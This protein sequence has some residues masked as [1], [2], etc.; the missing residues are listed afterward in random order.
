M[1]NFQD[2]YPL[3]L[4]VGLTLGLGWLVWYQVS[5]STQQ[6]QDRGVLSQSERL[7]LGLSA[8]LGGVL[9][10][11][12]G[13]VASMFS[14]YLVPP[15]LI[16]MFWEGGLSWVGAALGALAGLWAYTARNGKPFWRA[17]DALA[18][19][20][21]WVSLAGWIGCQLNRCAYGRVASGSPLALPMPDLMGSIEPRW[22]TQAA[23]GLLSLVGLILLLRL[24]PASLPPGILAATSLS[25]ISLIAFFTGWFRGDPVPV[26][27]DLRLDGLAAGVMLVLSTGILAYRWK[28]T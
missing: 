2:S 25:W 24:L 4:V 13:H 27:G 5:T 11:R 6:S 26:V 7:D 10:A 8:A 12:L 3:I 20:A 19:P 17:A 1:V 28:V 22:P 9:G 18:V 14:Y 16:L 15:R 23:G 21:M